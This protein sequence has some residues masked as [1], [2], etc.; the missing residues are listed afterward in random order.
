MGWRKAARQQGSVNILKEIEAHQLKC[1]RFS[2]ADQHGVLRGKTLAAAEVRGALERGVTVTSTL[3]LKDT[4][5]KTVFP[6]FTPGGGVGMPELQG[7]ADILMMPDESTFRILPWAPDTGWMLCDLR[8]QDGGAVPFDSRNVLRKALGKLGEHEFIAGLEV[9]FHVFRIVDEHLRPSDA[10]QPG[11]PPEVELLTTGYQYLTEQR[12]DQID[13]VVQLLRAGLE[14]LQLPL[15]S[16]EV[17]FGPSQFEFT[18]APLAGPHRLGQGE[19]RCAAARD[20]R[21][22]QSRDAHRKSHRRAGGESLSLFRLADLLRPRRH[23]DTPGAARFS[24]HAVRGKGGAAAG[25]A[26][27]GARGAAQGQGAARGHRR[28]LRRLLLP[29]QASRARPL[30]P[31]SERL[32]AAR[33]LRPVLNIGK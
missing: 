32:G 19:P 5:H 29:H 22:G 31:L 23:G 11:T 8:L 9:E 33:V 4:A 25:H 14:Q 6:A 18:L 13:P 20:R 10:G 27:R 26:R 2:F 16:F 28:N 3:L 30:Q 21:A 7:A 24:R 17:E 15:R 12:Y 1:V